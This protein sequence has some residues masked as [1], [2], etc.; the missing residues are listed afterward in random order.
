LFN[1]TKWNKNVNGIKLSYHHVSGIGQ[2][3]RERERNRFETNIYSA[4]HHAV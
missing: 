4:Q 2:R 1:S 3:E